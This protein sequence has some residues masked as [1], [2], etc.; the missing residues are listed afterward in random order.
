MKLP[1]QRFSAPLIARRRTPKIVEQYAQIGGGSPIL[2]WTQTQ[3]AGLCALLDELHPS[4]APHKPYIG[5]RYAKP[6]VE[7]AAK[8]MKGDGVKR[9]VAFTQY[10]Q[11]SCSTTGSSLNE[12]YRRGRAGEFGEGV[13]WSVIDR[14]FSHPGLVEVSEYL[15][16]LSSDVRDRLNVPRHLHRILKPPF[17]STRTTG[18]RTSCYFSRRILSQCPSSIGAI[19]TSWRCQQ[20]SRQ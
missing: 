9:A 16:S 20:P 4:T 10:P 18:E 2:R 13:R 8:Q 5:F 19:L 11:Y 1:L 14:W 12:V 7:N 6:L 3:G 17:K 15:R